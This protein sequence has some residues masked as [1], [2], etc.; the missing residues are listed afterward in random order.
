MCP[1]CCCQG[2]NRTAPSWCC[3]P[4][5][6]RMWRNM[7]GRAR[8]VEAKKRACVGVW[9]LLDSSSASNDAHTPRYGRSNAPPFLPWYGMQQRHM[10]DKMQKT[11]SAHRT[12]ACCSLVHV[13]RHSRASDSTLDGDS[14]CCRGESREG[15]ESKHGWI[16]SV[17]VCVCVCV[18]VLEFGLH[19]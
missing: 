2:R 12:R 17:C 5:G 19:W 10:T 3:L 6:V 15:D 7:V 4:P 11:N 16:G 13:Q 18:C 8:A 1:C 14:G 9:Q